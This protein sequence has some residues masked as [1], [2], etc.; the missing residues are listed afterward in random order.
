MVSGNF[1]E[2][3]SFLRHLGIFSMPQI[4]DMGLTAL[5]PLRRKACWEFKLYFIVYQRLNSAIGI[6]APKLRLQA[7]FFGFSCCSF[8]KLNDFGP[9]SRQIWLC[10]CY[11]RCGETTARLFTFRLVKMSLRSARVLLFGLLAT[12]DL[13]LFM[14]APQIHLLPSL[15]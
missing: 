3:T 7:V 11:R 10:D 2:I 12:S 9:F 1:A 15:Q 8:A 4:Y 14:C 13:L 5:L 6:V